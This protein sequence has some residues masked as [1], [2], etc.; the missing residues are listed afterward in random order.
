V[1]RSRPVYAI[2]ALLATT[3][4]AWAIGLASAGISWGPGIVAEVLGSSA[5]VLMGANLVLATRFRFAER[6]FEGLDRVYA[7]HRLIGITVALLIVPHFAL[8][9]SPVPPSL[10]R[11]IGIV[12]LVLLLASVMLAVAPRSSRNRPAPLRYQDWKRGHRLNGVIVALV[13][14]H[15]LLVVSALVNLPL[16]AAWVYGWAGVGLACY[17]YRL[18]F[19]RAVAE[20][21]HYSVASVEHLGESVTQVSLVPVTEPIAAKPGQFAFVRISEGPGCEQ[22]PFTISA[23]VVD[24]RVRFSIHALGDWTRRLRDTITTGDAATLEGPY[25]CFDA[26]RGGRRQLWLAG[27][28]GITPFLAML[29]CIPDDREVTLVWSVHAASDAIYLAE[30]ERAIAEHPGAHFKLHSSSESGHLDLATLGIERPA[31]LSLFVCGPK[32]MRHELV[33]Q[34]RALGV[35]SEAIFYEEF[36]LT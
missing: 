21:L 36:A 27:G 33:R 12:A 32:E 5:L 22:H 11:G 24:G 17:T 29:Q 20:R 9:L 35:R 13:V 1:H 3:W 28:I 14:A 18:T 25:G 10:A 2:A 19:Q 31:E 23:P 30:I 16:V 6:I 15:S 8:M 7:A 4:L 26:S 34:A